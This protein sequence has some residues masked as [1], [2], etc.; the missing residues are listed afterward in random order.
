MNELQNMLWM[1]GGLAMFLG[2]AIVSIIFFGLNGSET[3][4]N[5][6]K[7]STVEEYA[8]GSSLTDSGTTGTTSCDMHHSC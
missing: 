7:P 1:C 2:P 5:T 8:S 3:R 4:S 6:A